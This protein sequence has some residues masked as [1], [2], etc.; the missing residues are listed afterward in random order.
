[1]KIEIL[2]MGC[3]RCQKA[4]QIVTSTLKKFEKSAAVEHVTDAA[5]IVKRGVMH[6]PAI[7]IDGIIK[8]QGRVPSIEELNKALV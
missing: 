7:A 4:E 1:M 5:E 8:F 3:S 2:G 6:T